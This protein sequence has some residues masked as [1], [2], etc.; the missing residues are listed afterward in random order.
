MARLTNV[1]VIGV[2]ELGAKH[3]RVYTELPEAQLVGVCDVDSDRANEVAS[4]YGVV[5]TRADS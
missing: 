3:A 4:L 5:R 2:G 1:A